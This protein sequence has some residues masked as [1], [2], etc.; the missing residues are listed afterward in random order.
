MKKYFSILICW[1]YPGLENCINEHPKPSVSC[2]TI[3]HKITF[4]IRER[5]VSLKGK[6]TDDSNEWKPSNHEE[7]VAFLGYYHGSNK[8]EQ[9]WELAEIPKVAPRSTP[10]FLS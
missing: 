9:V 1:Q 5:K 10:I 7:L 8:Y 4:V 2:W 3:M 6:L